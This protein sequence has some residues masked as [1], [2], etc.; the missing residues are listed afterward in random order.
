VEEIQ[1]HRYSDVWTLPSI[2]FPDYKY[3]CAAGWPKRPI[4]ITHVKNERTRRAKYIPKLVGFESSGAL[5]QSSADPAFP[6]KVRNS[7]WE[8][9]SLDDKPVMYIGR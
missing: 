6:A 3:S 9:Q 2:L 4:V 7:I 8:G 5:G 1:I